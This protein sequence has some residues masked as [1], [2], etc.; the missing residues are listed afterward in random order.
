MAKTQNALFITQPTSNL[1]HVLQGNVNQVKFL[2]HDAQ[3]KYPRTAGCF[4]TFLERF[5]S[6][7]RTRYDVSRVSLQYGDF[8]VLCHV[9][10]LTGLR[11]VRMSQWFKRV[12]YN[13]WMIGLT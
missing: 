2:R 12:L 1:L 13:L 8:A 10:L 7:Y 5:V 3:L 9:A 11:D 6:S 4:H